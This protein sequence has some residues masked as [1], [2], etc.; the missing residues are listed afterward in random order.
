MLLKPHGNSAR[1]RFVC[2]ESRLAQKL[3]CKAW[4]QL[5]PQRKTEFI[6]GGFR[7]ETV[8]KHIYIGFIDGYF[9]SCS[10]N[11]IYVDEM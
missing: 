10:E 7:D 9:L 1:G 2:I 4:Q 8:I 6:S 3:V 5:K 11:N